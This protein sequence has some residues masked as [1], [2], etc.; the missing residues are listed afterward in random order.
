MQK[1]QNKNKTET[2]KPLPL[3]EVRG[4]GVH[5]YTRR[6]TA[7]G[8]E[9]EEGHRGG[10]G[11]QKCVS[12]SV[13]A[14]TVPSPLSLASQSL[15]ATV[16]GPAPSMPRIFR[17]ALGIINLRNLYTVGEEKSCLR[18]LLE[19]LGGPASAPPNCTA[20]TL[21]GRGAWKRQARLGVL[22]WAMR[23]PG[24]LFPAPTPGHGD[25]RVPALGD[26]GD[27]ERS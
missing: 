27:D 26:E 5:L 24:D 1:K 20:D 11:A 3:G 14:A 18:R 2:S 10:R 4:S 19:S 8:E 21:G 16:R 6:W 12:F 23:R 25:H 17:S 22:P 15:T 13:I 9:Q 7:G